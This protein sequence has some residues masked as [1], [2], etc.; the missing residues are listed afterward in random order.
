MGSTPHRNLLTFGELTG[1]QSA[2][3]IILVSTMWDI[4][5]P[6]ADVGDRREQ[7][8][9]DEYWDVMI[10]H[11]ATVARFLNNSDSAWEIIDNFISRT[12]EIK[13]T[14]L[15]FQDERVVQKKKLEETSAG[16]ALSWNLDEL[17]RRQR[18]RPL[19]KVTE[20]RE[21]G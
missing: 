11:G 20:M 14:K 15:T 17:V 6:M 19:A 8:L 7:R 12:Q 2:D 1:S 18:K 13:K 10:Y 16:E 9:K 4:L 21:I 5:G 3:N